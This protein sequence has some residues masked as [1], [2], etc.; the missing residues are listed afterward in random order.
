MTQ[1]KKAVVLVTGSS[2]G[3]GLAL[4]KYLVSEDYF[5]VGVD[6]DEIF[7]G[8]KSEENYSHKICNLADLECI[9]ALVSSLKELERIDVIINN[10]AIIRPSLFRKIDDTDFDLV[11]KVNLY[12]AVFLTQGL[13]PKLKASMHAPHVFNVGST[14][15][16]VGAPYLTSYVCSKSAIHGLTLAINQENSFFGKIKATTI[17]FGPILTPMNDSL[18]GWPGIWKKNNPVALDPNKISQV[19]ELYI[20][21][22]ADIFVEDITITGREMNNE[23]LAENPVLSSL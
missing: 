20:R 23:R 2:S 7:A 19:I 9:R 16:V 6:K 11:M 22:R 12:A 18:E 15:G 17:N 1:Q 10:A 21:L 3:L 5:V 14:A 13:L 4:V 8:L